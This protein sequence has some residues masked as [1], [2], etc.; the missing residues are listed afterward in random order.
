M[1]I[2]YS[3]WLGECY[4]FRCIPESHIKSN[5]EVGGQSS[6]VQSQ[7]QYSG[8]ANMMLETAFFCIDF[9]WS[10]STTIATT[11]ALLLKAFVL[12]VGVRWL[13]R[14]ANIKQPRS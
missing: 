4:I 9:V 5:N 1:R 12:K 13:F 10:R 14:G 2:K 6:Q 3:Q 7:D 11:L 8:G